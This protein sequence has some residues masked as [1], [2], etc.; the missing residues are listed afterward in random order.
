MYRSRG[1]RKSRSRGTRENRVPFVG[2]IFRR[3]VRRK[4]DGLR[5]LRGRVLHLAAWTAARGNVSLRQTTYILKISLL[6]HECAR[7]RAPASTSASGLIRGNRKKER[8]RREGRRRRRERSQ[9]YEQLCGPFYEPPFKTKLREHA[10][11]TRPAVA[12]AKHSS[13]IPVLSYM[14]P[15]IQALMLI[16]DYLLRVRLLGVHCSSSARRE[17]ALTCLAFGDAAR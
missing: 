8:Q 17:M 1:G 6:E 12:A 14:A 5:Q 13:F 10:T 16:T 4:A 9:L 2:S 7:A 11:R 15:G 3:S